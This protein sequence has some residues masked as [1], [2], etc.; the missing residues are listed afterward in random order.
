[1]EG[2]GYRD[3]AAEFAK[4]GVQIVGVSFDPPAE[5]QA[6]AEE[7]ELPFELWTDNDREL[8]LYYGAATTPEQG[9]ANRRSYLL[10][11]DGYVLLEYPV[12]STG[13]HPAQVLADCEALFG[14]L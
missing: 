4:L 5:N 7:H 14:T 8:A 11:A 13:V 10:D 3:H 2:C 6:W 1:M 9:A 12:V